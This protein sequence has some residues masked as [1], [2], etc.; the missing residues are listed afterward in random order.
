MSLK[1]YLVAVLLIF[2]LAGC[3]NAAD[4]DTTNRDS[5]SSD[6]KKVESR[7]DSLYRQ[8]M[9]IHNEVMAKMGKLNGYKKKVQQQTDSVRSMLAFTDFPRQVAQRIASDLDS[10]DMLGKRLQAADSSMNAW[11]EQFNPDPELPDS[12]AR[13]DYF[14]KQKQ[15]ALAMKKMFFDALKSADDLYA[16]RKQ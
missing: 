16:Q 9:D 8:T 12:N 15:S 14:E 11:M 10:L 4:T 5:G 7:E 13:A 1:E 6:G 3:N 2:F